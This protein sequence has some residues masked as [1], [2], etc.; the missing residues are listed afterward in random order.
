MK[1][2]FSEESCTEQVVNHEKF[3]LTD[4]QDSKQPSFSTTKS[5]HEWLATVLNKNYQLIQFTGIDF[6]KYFK[7]LFKSDKKCDGMLYYKE[8]PNKAVIF[9]EL[10][11]G[12]NTTK[13]IFKAKQQL[14]STVEK[15]RM[16]HNISEF[17]ERKV[18]AANSLDS[19]T[20][21]VRQNDI[22]E[23]F[24]LGFD[25]YVKSVIEM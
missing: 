22:E 9:V 5:D 20:I 17:E 19:N 12:L 13:W 1:D 18:F 11:S 7:D 6:N 10:K 23:F 25:F 14:L 24:E 15:F 4:V 21:S 8:N 2:F 16:C 3:G